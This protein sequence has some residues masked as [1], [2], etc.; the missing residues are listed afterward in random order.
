M[1][2]YQWVHNAYIRLSK[3]FNNSYI[4]NE[5]EILF[6]RVM[7]VS[8]SE[9]I[10]YSDTLLT[11]IQLIKL[12]SF[13]I[14]REN[15]EPIAYIFGEQEFWS[16]KLFVSY[17]TFIPRFD[18]E[19]LIEQ[20]LKLV[21][22]NDAKVLDLG[23]GSGA[24]ALS[25]ASEKPNWQIFAADCSL[26][27]LVIAK[28]NA[29]N[30]GI[31]N[32]VF[33]HSNWFESLDIKLYDLIVSNPPYISFKEFN[34]LNKE[35]FYEP[36]CSLLSLNNGLLDLEVICLNANN[37]LVP[38]GWLILEHGCNQGVAVRSFFNRG[39]FSNISTIKDYCNNDRV[40]QG[41]KV[42]FNKT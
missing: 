29:L 21:T 26:D 27:A 35:I 39:V 30:L 23:T 1:S 28:K 14:R 15:F 36:R 42:I 32:V 22:L 8:L 34:F 11:N 24:I 7:G 9:F 6:C 12:E 18:T 25:L 40:T 41:Q 5:I 4:R 16:L 33:F 31:K 20:S 13:L 10:L 2:W 17:D 3:L 38:G 19:C 37:Y